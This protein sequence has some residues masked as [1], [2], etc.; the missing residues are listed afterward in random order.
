[1]PGGAVVGAAR[2][3]LLRAPAELRPDEREHAVGDA[4]RLEIALERVERR[5]GRRQRGRRAPRPGPRACRTRRSPRARRSAA[6]ARP[7]SSPRGPAGCVGNESLPVGYGDRRRD[8]V[9]GRRTAAAGGAAVSACAVTSADRAHG[10]V[11]A[12]GRAPSV[13]I[14][15]SMRVST[16][17]QTPGDPEVVLARGRRSPRPAPWPS[18][19]SAAASRSATAP[20]AGC[21]ASRR[22]RGSGPSSRS[23]AT[24]RSRRPP[25]SGAT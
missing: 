14:A 19:A 5:G 16:S 6:A 2:A 1:M 9:L 18:R 13:P 10:R 11:A 22:R 8:R 3:V 21:R 24:D 17:P 20:A 23:A 4:A 12:S 7:R 15:S 25:R